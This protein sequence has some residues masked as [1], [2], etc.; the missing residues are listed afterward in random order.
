MPRS[1]R[2][3]LHQGLSALRSAATILMPVLAAALAAA[4]ALAIAGLGPALHLDAAW[5]GEPIPDAGL[6]AEGL[7]AGLLLLLCAFLPAN[8]RMQRLERSHRDFH[9]GME[10]VAR[11]YALA[12]REDRSGAFTLS[13]EFDAV[14]ERIAFLRHHPDLAT[15][16]PE[17]L[18]V[19]G[20]MSQIAR[21]LARV[22]SDEKLARARA[23][24]TQRQEE[25]AALADRIRLAHYATAELKRWMQDVEADEKT[26]A[27]QLERLERDL[28][29]VLPALGYD[30]EDVPGNVVQMPAKPK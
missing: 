30:F 4:T 13:A 9:I 6:W 2:S 14:R 22:Y 8:A 19:A 24:L 29:D 20:Q 25:N 10:D 18:E 3:V 11:A 15:L 28:H 1:T 26:V 27:T 7:V 17:V 23:F 21:D 12:H 5:N 16:E